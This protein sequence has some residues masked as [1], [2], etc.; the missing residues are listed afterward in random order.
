[1]ALTGLRLSVITA[2]AGTASIGIYGNAV[3]GAD[4]VPGSLLASVTGL[5]TGV[6]GNVTGTL[7]YTLT[8]G[9]LYWASIICSAA[10][11]LRALTVS[12]IQS[13]LGRAS[14]STAVVSHVYAAGS[15]STLPAT[16]PAVTDAVGA[17]TPAIYLVE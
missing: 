12:S 1:V 6:A 17:V 16:A 10:P 9:T 15:G 2:V 14:N 8:A 5:S 13:C 3:S 11:S 7:S 4:D